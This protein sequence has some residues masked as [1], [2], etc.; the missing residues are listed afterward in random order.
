MLH[1]CFHEN[2]RTSKN[3][4]RLRRIRLNDNQSGNQEAR[5]NWIH[6]ISGEALEKI[7]NRVDIILES[8]DEDSHLRDFAGQLE[9]IISEISEQY[10]G[11]LCSTELWKGVAFITLMLE[12]DKLEKLVMQI[13][14][15]PE[16]EKVDEGFLFGKQPGN[17]EE[18]TGAIACPLKL[19]HTPTF[20]VVLKNDSVFG[21]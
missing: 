13:A 20:R 6:H 11:V 16:V 9:E 21:Y 17:D 15:L 7:S 3:L 1:D 5:L 14:L 18:I 19:H 10:G 4:V 2:G 12:L 8:P